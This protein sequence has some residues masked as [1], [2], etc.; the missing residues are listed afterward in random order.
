MCCLQLGPGA[1]RAEAKKWGAG[2][3]GSGCYRR[4][5]GHELGW[6][7]KT[8]AVLPVRT[9]GQCGVKPPKAP[10][11]TQRHHFLSAL[12]SPGAG[13]KLGCLLSSLGPGPWA[14][15]VTPSQSEQ[16]L[17]GWVVG[18]LAPQAH[19]GFRVG[20]LGTGLFSLSWTLV[21]EL[22]FGVA[23]T[24]LGGLSLSPDPEPCSEAAVGAG[25]TPLA[26]LGSLPRTCG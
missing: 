2:V 19:W 18:A 16:G 24:A 25:L 3:G 20:G 11:W 10:P 6:P 5:Q 15:T 22:G 17:L 23:S 12:S 14:L 9:R 1:G 4:A 13:P 26:P 7:S 8:Q 21:L